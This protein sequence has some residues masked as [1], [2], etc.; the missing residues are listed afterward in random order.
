L[1]S[2][3]I[4]DM[5]L[6]VSGSAETAK[7]AEDVFDVLVGPSGLDWIES[8][9]ELHQ[10]GVLKQGSSLAWNLGRRKKV[11]TPVNVDRPRLISWS[12]RGLKGQ[13][14]IEKLNGRTRVSWT[15]EFPVVSS[16]LIDLVFSLFMMPRLSRIA[17]E[18]SSAG[19]RDLVR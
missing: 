16:G 5:K 12:G 4:F 8:P 15:G 13:I 2:N 3:K 7:S 11:Q 6:R 14:T 19:L 9:W 18:E 1:D 17:S 10:A